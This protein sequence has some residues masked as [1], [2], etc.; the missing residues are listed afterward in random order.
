MRSRW[1]IALAV[2]LA[3]LVYAQEPVEVA[4]R[5]RTQPLSRPA[6]APKAAKTE[7]PA[8]TPKATASHVLAGMVVDISGHMIAVQQTSDQTIFMAHLPTALPNGL[9]PGM[10]VTVD[11]KFGHGFIHAD[12]VTITNKDI[13]WPAVSTPAQTSGHIDHIVFVIQEGHS[14][15]NY[16]GT[17]PGA[18]GLPANLLVPLKPGSAPTMPAFH[19]T[20]DPRQDLDRSYET[21][22]AAID[23]GKMDGWI[24]AE[25]TIDTLGHFDDSDIPNYWAYAKHFVL[26]DNF[27]SSLAGPSLPN[28]L[29]TVAAQSGG[30]EKNLTQAPKGGFNFPTLPELLGPSN[31]SW[32][33]YVGTHPDLFSPANPLPGFTRFM[34]DPGLMSHLVQNT[35]L[36]RDLREGTLPSVAWIVPNATESEH[37]NADIRVGMWY[38][39]ALANALMKSAYWQNTL[40]VV[41]WDDYGGYYDH[42]APPQ[43]DAL[44]Y[45][46]RVPALLISSY[47]RPGF[48]DH[49]QYDFTSVLRSIE[50][51]FGLQPLTNRDH[52]A[53]TLTA[54]LDMTQ[55]PAKPFV[56]EAPI[57]N[58]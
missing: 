33:Y 50:H 36:F 2:L 20:F 46:P 51:R 19:F 29:Y 7:K 6:P 4:L 3:G 48:I 55:T 53:N 27:F 25:R 57:G 8:K 17:Y 39:T 22:R 56:I 23:S 38:V 34:Q 15:D 52:Q 54:G 21:A 16:F 5:Y 35:V 58:P 43:V 44:G 10:T 13:A 32:K 40:L 1:F 42:V 47:A 30:N 9:A 37:P 12:R 14:F 11:G 45:G 31:V 49:T 41:T 26:E 24:P 18:N 28:H